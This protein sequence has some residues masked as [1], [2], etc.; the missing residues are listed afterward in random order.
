MVD[1]TSPI[2][3]TFELQRQTI[4]QSQ[5]A[6]EQGIQFQQDF[7]RAL[8]GGL[9]GQEDAQRRVVELQR[10]AV[11]D[12]LDTVEANIPGSEDATAEMRETV[13]EQFDQLLDNHEE[14]FETLTAEMEDGAESYENLVSEYLDTLDDQLEMLIDAHEGLEE[15][16][17]ETAEELTEQ[18]DQLQSQVEDVQQQVEE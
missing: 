3:A 4:K 17:V 1:Y 16:S 8:V 10:N 13:D 15:Q 7:N 5:E 12:A 11:L 14:A 2:T 6:L 9:D 18:L